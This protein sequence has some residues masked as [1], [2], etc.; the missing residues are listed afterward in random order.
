M[1]P[2][3]WPTKASQCLA[4]RQLIGKRERTEESPDEEIA[5]PAQPR[6]LIPESNIPGIS[7]RDSIALF[8][9]WYGETQADFRNFGRHFHIARLLD[10]STFQE[11]W[12][13]LVYLCEERPVQKSHPDSSRIE[14]AL[15]RRHEVDG[16]LVQLTL[17]YEEAT[18]KTNPAFHR[19]NTLTFYLLRADELES[20][21]W[22]DHLVTRRGDNNQQSIDRMGGLHESVLSTLVDLLMAPAML[23]WGGKT[24]L[25]TDTFRQVQHIK[26]DE[27]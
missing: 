9:S 22:R 12:Q 10:T 16:G 21:R 4:W 15:Q 27:D 1:K 26:T 23:F 2:E 18:T 6:I 24:R 5:V 19:T 8:T 14:F 13:Y 20:G 17:T 3:S 25:P 7:K 11:Y